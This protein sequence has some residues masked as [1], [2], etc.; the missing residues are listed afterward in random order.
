MTAVNLPNVLT[1]LRVTAA[2]LLAW[3]L[4]TRQLELAFWVFVAAALTDALDGWIARR[5]GLLTPYGAVM[6]PLADKLVTLVC[7]VL[8]T[9]LEVVPLW[10]TLALVVRDTVIVGG[11]FAYQRAFGEVHIQPTRLGKLHTSVAF[12]L[13]AMVLAEGADYLDLTPW[14]QALFWM[15]FAFT[16]ASG[17]QY[18]VLWGRKAAQASRR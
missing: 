6:D 8:L 17:V 3:A 4:L 15:V 1:T 12:A 10:L 14:R 13:F 18:V 5:F 7:V 11:A 2:P 9:W 16:L